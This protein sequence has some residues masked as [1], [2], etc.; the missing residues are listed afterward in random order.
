M[1]NP[2]KKAES[3]KLENEVEL[4]VKQLE[5][6][7][8]PENLVDSES[9]DV[10]LE[11]LTDYF[12]QCEKNGIEMTRDMV[13]TEIRER[14]G[15]EVDDLLGEE[16]TD[17]ELKL[18]HQEIISKI[19]EVMSQKAEDKSTTL[20]FLRDKVFKSKF[21]KAAF[22]TALLFLKFNP[23]HAA[24]NKDNKENVKDK[25][26]HEIKKPVSQEGDGDKT[27]KTS[28]EDFNHLVISATNSFETDKADLKDNGKLAADFDK[29]LSAI[30]KTNFNDLINQDWSV[31]GSSDERRT[32]LPGGNEELTK[33]RIEAVKSV[34]EKTLASHNFSDKLSSEQ[35][36]QILEKKINEVYPTT[37][38]EKGVTHLT[39]LVNQASGQNYTEAEIKIIKETNPSEYHKMLDKCR[40]TN[41]ELSVK[42]SIYETEKVEPIKAKPA[43][44]KVNTKTPEIPKIITGD[45]YDKYYFLVDNSSSMGGTKKN[46]A[47]E[48]SGLNI[49]KPFM[50]ASYSDDLS[51]VK[52]EKSSQD[53]AKKMVK[54][55]TEHS[56]NL[57]KTFSSAVKFLEKIEKQALK[58]A[59]NNEPLPRGIMYIA[60]DE[61][62]QDVNHLDQLKELSLKTNTQI[63]V[64]VFH[65]S[66]RQVLRLSL[67]DVQKQIS[68]N[69]IIKLH[70]YDKSGKNLG[71]RWVMKK[72]VDANGKIVAGR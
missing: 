1:F 14:L 13:E 59:K 60:T 58:Q 20:S 53:M 7:E 15:I 29:F 56:S 40:Y 68:A 3:P 27:F 63:E 42:E 2:F 36:K 30:D 66:G 37:G 4:P 10:R 50:M 17:P 64:L 41:F 24:D 33:A 45:N 32:S 72:I 38:A 43:D 46:M 25:I 62:L 44:L 57:E 55:D 6:L 48:L 51:G 67:D 47:K 39:D 69:N 49:N 54:M 61:T 31:K 8:T 5:T 52:T 35:I 34:I 11:A 16:I 18:T 12:N 23:V 26:E 22:V 21:A 19:N 9:I 70:D 65:N 28:V 71:E